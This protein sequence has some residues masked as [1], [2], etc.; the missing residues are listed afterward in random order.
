LQNC[1]TFGDAAGISWAPL[2]FTA[3]YIATFL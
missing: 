2:F 1:S 3:S